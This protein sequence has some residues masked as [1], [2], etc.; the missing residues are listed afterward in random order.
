[1]K[2]IL[3]Q[4]SFLVILFL[5]ISFLTANPCRAQI[6]VMGPVEV[7]L[8]G[9]FLSLDA[10]GDLNTYVLW[11]RGTKWHFQIKSI[12]VQSPWI[13]N[14]WD[15]LHEITPPHLHLIGKEKTIQR[16]KQPDVIGKSFRLQGT[17][18]VADGIFHITSEEDVSKKEEAS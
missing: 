11:V 4:N 3:G 16:L 10:K 15:L 9:T 14:D 12:R 7:I 5:F 6:A 8:T 1:M 17:L 18:Y 13:V 2:K